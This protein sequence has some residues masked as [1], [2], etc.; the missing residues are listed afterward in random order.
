MLNL[1]SCDG[2]KSSLDVGNVLLKVSWARILFQHCQP[3]WITLLWRP[4][5]TPTVPPPLQ[6]GCSRCPCPGRRLSIF[7]APQSSKT[8]LRMT[9]RRSGC[10]GG[11]RGSLICS[12]APT[13]LACWPPP[14]AG[15]GLLGW[16]SLSSRLDVGCVGPGISTKLYGSRFWKFK[17]SWILARVVCFCFPFRIIDVSATMPKFTNT[18]ITEH[19]STCI[20]LSTENVSI[21]WFST[22]D[23]IPWSQGQS[24]YLVSVENAQSMMMI[25]QWVILVLVVSTRSAGGFT[26]SSRPVVHLLRGCLL[27]AVYLER[28]HGTW[29]NSRVLELAWV[30]GYML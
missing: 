2:L 25:L 19:Y 27:S 24:S 10:S 23:V 4:E 5:D 21:C 28:Q 14:P 6:S 7:P 8:F 29:V 18:Q 1:P 26:V 16:L 15:E 20:K 11:G 13:R 12:S 22:E 9:M 17:L 30:G 3:Q